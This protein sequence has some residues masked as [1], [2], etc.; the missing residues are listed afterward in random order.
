MAGQQINIA[1]N[2]PMDVESHDLISGEPAFTRKNSYLYKGT[3]SNLT[4][5]EGDGILSTTGN[6]IKVGSDGIHTGNI[7][8]PLP[9]ELKVVKGYERIDSYKD[10]LFARRLATG[11]AYI[12]RP[13][14]TTLLVHVPGYD[15]WSVANNDVVMLSGNKDALPYSINGFITQNRSVGFEHPN[16]VLVTKHYY[17][18]ETERY[19][20]KYEMYDLSGNLLHTW[21]DEWIS[22]LHTEREGNKDWS[23]GD[24]FTSYIRAEEIGGLKYN[25]IYWGFDDP[26]MRRRF[27][28][29]TYYYYNP[30][31]NIEPAYDSDGVDE[32]TYNSNEG[33]DEVLYNKAKFVYSTVET[34]ELNGQSVS[35]LGVLPI[36]RGFGLISDKG[37]V[38]GEPLVEKRPQNQD[39]TITRGRGLWNTRFRELDN[40]VIVTEVPNSTSGNRYWDGSQYQTESLNRYVQNNSLGNN[41]T[42]YNSGTQS[43]MANWAATPWNQFVDNDDNTSHGYFYNWIL[44]INLN[45]GEDYQ[46][47]PACSTF[48][49]LVNPVAHL[50]FFNFSDPVGSFNKEPMADEQ[51]FPHMRFFMNVQEDRGKYWDYGKGWNSMVVDQLYINKYNRYG[52]AVW[53]TPLSVIYNTAENIYSDNINI[54]EHNHDDRELRLLDAV[55]KPASVEW[56]STLNRFKLITELPVLDTAATDYPLNDQLKF[57]RETDFQASLTDTSVGEEHSFVSQVYR[58]HPITASMISGNFYQNHSWTGFE[59]QCTMGIISHTFSL[60]DNLNLGVYASIPVAL[61]AYGTLLFTPQDIGDSFSFDINENG[62][63]VTRFSRD[64]IESVEIKSNATWNDV[65]VSKLA[66]YEFR[67]NILGDRNLIVEDHRG[68]FSME[69]AFYP[70]IMDSFFTNYYDISCPSDSTTPASNGVWYYG[71]GKNFRLNGDISETSTF[72]LAPFTLSIY[73]QTSETDYFNRIALDNRN[74]KLL[75]DLWCFGNGD[76]VDE[77]YTFSRKTTA[78]EYKN[79]RYINEA[80]IQ[81]SKYLTE[82]AGTVWWAGAQGV[83]IYPVGIVSKVDGVDYTTPTVDAGNNYSARFYRNTNKTFLVFNQNDMVYFG[84]RIFTIMSGNYY[85]DGQGIYYLGS[86][87]DYSQNIFTAYAIGMKFLANSSAEAYFYSEWD[88]SLYLYTASN[89]L[90]KSQSFAAMGDIVDS[91]YSSAEQALYILFEGGRL[92][93]KTQT[94]SAILEGIQG[95]RLQ[96]TS[97]GCQILDT[98]KGT[99]ETYN[100]HK[101]ENHVPLMLETEWLG[102][103][104]SVQKYPYLDV[105]LQDVTRSS[106]PRILVEFLAINGSDIKHDTMEIEIDRNKWLNQLLRIRLNPSEI[107]GCAFKLKLYSEDIINIFSVSVNVDNDSGM[108]GAPHDISIKE[109]PNQTIEEIIDSGKED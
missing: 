60:D 35:N 30:D 20:N 105:V 12:R 101:W 75:A 54:T 26:D 99:Y 71:A 66:D 36:A 88:K 17:E 102:A 41:P 40:G 46:T 15:D 94:D 61:S 83:V 106:T 77:F 80:G 11:T 92:Y 104:D 76:E 1:L 64:T 19:Y 79:T 72:L 27:L 47:L 91:L 84:N 50:T 42:S 58:L 37:Y 48:A 108:P 87:D 65:T 44:S 103:S 5:R 74:G 93:V 33:I 10:C 28:F 78:I 69:R 49:G 34:T 51:V 24:R 43:G 25:F 4:R 86:R 82:Y 73:V 109:H 21:E 95:N 31:Y 18:K 68:N 96:S 3:L 97:W 22:E 56:D 85:F 52:V 7:L 59:E 16:L 100:P 6:G 81:Q 45:Q 38:Y 53:E 8:F 13:S 14:P 107:D 98:D 29:R 32:A 39:P 9:K 89:T 23:F 62:Y 67:T 63:Y 55:R 57:I 70:Y 90:Q 2:S